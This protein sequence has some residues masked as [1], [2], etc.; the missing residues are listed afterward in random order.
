MSNRNVKFYLTKIQIRSNFILKTTSIFEKSKYF[1]NNIPINY[2]VFV[3]KHK[4]T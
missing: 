4:N 1:I 3:H 2:H